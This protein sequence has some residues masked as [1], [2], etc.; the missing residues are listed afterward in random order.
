MRRSLIVLAVLTFA[1]TSQA[2]EQNERLLYDVMFGGLHVA[3]VVVTMNQTA[4]SYESSLAMRTRGVAESFQ[5]FRADMSS[6]GGF[7]EK[8]TAPSVHTRAWS[9]PKVASEMT[10]RYDPVNGMSQAVERLYHPITGAALK[11]EDLPWNNRRAPKPVPDNLRS[12][13]VDPVAAFIAAR[14]QVIE[15]GQKE[16]RV[17]IYDGRRRYDI[18]STVGKPRSATIKDVTRDVIPVVSKVEPVFGFEPDAEDRMRDSSGTTYFS[19]DERF[20]PVQIVLSNDLFSSVMNLRAECTMDPA[21]CEAFAQP[22][23]QKKSDAN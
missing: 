22:R 21:P 18:V 7:V 12:G 11:P 20:I 14:R 13:A 4:A 2:R 15:S 19:N 5:D 10:M 6:Q 9:S 1:S 17:P 3:D 16:V 8:R 23:G